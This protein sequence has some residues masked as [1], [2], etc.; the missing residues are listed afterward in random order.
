ETLCPFL[1]QGLV[2]HVADCLVTTP[3]R[4]LDDIEPR[5][6][7][8]EFCERLYPRTG[9]V[10]ARL[11]RLQA[12]LRTPVTSAAWLEDQFYAL[13]TAVG[14]LRFE[15]QKEVDQCPAVRATTRA[16]LYQRLHRGRDFISSCYAQ[17]LNVARIAHV[18]HLSPFYFQRLFRLAF[19]QTPMQYLQEQRLAVAR[20]LL[21][22]T[23]QPV[24]VVCLA[25]GFE[26]PG[27]F[28][29]LFRKRFRVSPRGFRAL[30][31]PGRNSQS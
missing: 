2:E 24:T 31:R 30:G 26:S 23:D 8:T 19:G 9:P 3:E 16:E 29:W 13:A 5:A 28:S 15:V 12:G 20:R 7:P 22:T 6:P 14:G 27:S 17:P 21:V 18:A 4:Q 11:A 1:Q 25:V 10:A